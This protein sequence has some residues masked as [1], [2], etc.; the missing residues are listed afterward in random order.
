MNVKFQKKIYSYRDDFEKC[1]GPF[2]L[3]QSDFDTD[4]IFAAIFQTV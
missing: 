1:G 4:F 2:H 3:G